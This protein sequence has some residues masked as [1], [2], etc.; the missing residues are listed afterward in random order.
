MDIR[1][2]LA[3]PLAILAPT[4][5]AVGQRLVKDIDP[6]QVARDSNP[7]FSP[8]HWVQLPGRG[9]VFAAEHPD[10][11]N[12]LWVTDGTAARTGLVSDPTGFIDFAGQVY[13]A[14]D[15]GVY[16][17]ELWA[18]D[19]TGSG[20]RLVKDIHPGSAGSA[21]SDFAVLLVT[22]IGHR[23]VF[24]ASDTRA[25]VG[26]GRELWISDG[27]AAGTVLLA[28]LYPGDRLGVP[29]SSSPTGMTKL[30][31][32]DG[33]E[34]LVFTAR[35]AG[36][37]TEIGATDGTAAG[38]RM[39]YDIRPGSSSSQPGGYRTV[40]GYDGS[41]GRV[42]FAADDGVHG[43]E[44]WSTNGLF[45]TR[46]EADLEP[47]PV[48]SAPRFANLEYG[49]MTMNAGVL[50]FH[51][52]VASRGREPCTI[53]RVRGLRTYDLRPGPVSSMTADAEMRAAP[54]AC[55]F[56]A[57]DGVHGRELWVA[58]D[59]NL[60]LAREVVL[61]S[62]GATFGALCDVGARGVFA[63]VDTSGGQDLRIW[64]Y[65]GATGAH[66]FC[67][68]VGQAPRNLKLI[69][70]LPGPVYQILYS[71]V[72]FDP[73]GRELWTCTSRAGSASLVADIAPAGARSGEPTGF[74]VV[75][76]QVFF[77]ATTVARGAELW[78]SDGTEAGTRLTRDIAFGADSSDPRGL[79]AFGNRVYFA[80]EDALAGEELWTSDGTTTWRVADLFPGPSGSF[81]TELTVWNGALYFRA[82]TAAGETLWRSDGTGA[83]TAVV[84][85]LAAGGPASPRT[86]TIYQ[87]SAGRPGPMYF[88][89]S[90]PALG[91]ELW[92]SDGTAAGTKVTADLN[93]GPGDGAIDAARSIAVRG[94][95]VLFA[96]TTPA[97]GLELYGYRP[98]TGGPTG[99][100]SLILDIR[101]GASG[102]SPFP[103]TFVPGALGGFVLFEADDGVHGREPW[104]SFGSTGTT[105]MVRDVEPGNGSSMQQ[106]ATAVTALNSAYVWTY[107]TV[108]GLE[109]CEIYAYGGNPP[110]LARRCE[111]FAGA[112]SSYH[113]GRLAKM[114][115]PGSDKRLVFAADDGV[116][117][118]EPWVGE[119]GFR[120]WL[121]VDVNP[122]PLSSGPTGFVRLGSEIL[123][124][125]DDGVHGRELMAVPLAWTGASIVE[126]A[127]PGCAG[128]N[129]VPRI[130][131]GLQPGT[132]HV[133]N[134]P[135]VGN[136]Y[137][138][139]R[140]QDAY[141][142]AA[143]GLFVSFWTDPLV[144]GPCTLHVGQA[145]IVLGAVAPGGQAYLPIPVPTD[146][147][148]VGAE[149]WMQW[150]V[151]DPNGAFIG[152]A[153]FSDA[154]HFVIGG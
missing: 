138:G 70:Q 97:T 126:T 148:L 39:I 42:F 76:S 121:L 100:I 142:G 54:V 56:A 84:L 101:P 86:L 71:G 20:T 90:T 60:R 19:G 46:L 68:P 32:V 33:R 107:E 48:G 50:C 67:S 2:A 75:G 153:A 140:L 13:F 106:S 151:R 125:A 115:V 118:I 93:P 99:T 80:A 14:A 18:T 3:I 43:V 11:G 82:T 94:G 83:G 92:V 110:Y 147:N 146:R 91:R 143:C 111:V 1:H 116:H 127:G 77:R 58:T 141:A 134:L 25:T 102:S 4:A 79:T 51:A 10:F 36:L 129:G 23:L 122:G 26:S 78:V 139:I 15:D 120:A 5:A 55:Y 34:R 38:T 132:P 124:G 150:L 130:L 59:R 44:L 145:P 89:A 149:L 104:V 114:L 62:G 53:D 74:C 133:L 24:A 8:A 57:N 22:G 27:T 88:T 28:D 128:T 96:G 52:E 95:L 49:D 61:G 47:G 37:G 41:S 81:P 85:D 135:Y 64:F 12:E 131:A 45:D 119:S 69:R 66:E 31:C 87:D 30:H 65:D 152:Y 103:L 9:L 6:T 117:G 112:G 108:G 72:G 98:P 29:Y 35:A 136:S 17:S 21:P 73:V 16:G 7:S 109:P 40:G 113:D 105:A 63:L 137:W 144:F 154:L 123:F